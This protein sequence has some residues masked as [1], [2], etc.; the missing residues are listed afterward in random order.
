MR[1]LEA[2][3][4]SG[5]APDHPP[6][7]MLE[8][9]KRQIGEHQP[10][11]TQ[12][13]QK[14]DFLDLGFQ[15]RRSLARGHGAEPFEPADPAVLDRCQQARQPRL[16]IGPGDRGDGFEQDLLLVA[17][18]GADEAAEVALAQQ[19]IIV[20]DKPGARA[21]HERGIV[22][23]RGRF[24]PQIS[25][26]ATLGM[27]ARFPAAERKQGGRLMVEQRAPPPVKRP[28]RG[29]PRRWTPQLA[30][31]MLQHPG[32]DAPAPRPG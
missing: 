31:E 24:T 15:A 13:L 12:F 6:R 29:D 1:I 8:A 18:R 28:D 22:E 2:H 27:V 17:P 32:R 10:V 23:H 11:G 5:L 19:E 14:A 7:E 26:K 21:C 30:A 3:Q 4:R 16:P 20:I 25:D 9:G